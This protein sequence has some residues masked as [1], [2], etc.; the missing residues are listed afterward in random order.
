M[1]LVLPW[2]EVVT[3]V[4]LFLGIARRTAARILGVLL[5]VFIVALVDQPR[6]GR[7]VDCGCFGTAPKVPKTEA[8]R[9]A[10]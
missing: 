8:Q 2:L 1:A 9:L 7:P 5:I 4:A 10:T 3:G 6:P